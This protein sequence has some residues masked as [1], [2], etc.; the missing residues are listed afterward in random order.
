[1]T[2]KTLY[3]LPIASLIALWVILG[4]GCHKPDDNPAGDNL[5]ATTMEDLKIAEDFTWRTNRALLIDLSFTFSDGTPASFAPF[6]LFSGGKLILEATANQNGHFTLQH[7]VADIFNQVEVRSGNTPAI[8]LPLTPTEYHNLPAYQVVGDYTLNIAPV[9]KKGVLNQMHYPSR[10]TYGTIVFEDSWPYKADFDFNDMVIDFQ[11][12]AYLN[13]EAMVSDMLINLTLRAAGGSF[14][15]SFGLSF[16]N[17]WLDSPNNAPD[18]QTITVNDQPIQPR[19]TDYPSYIIFNNAHD[20][21][22][23]NTDPEKPYQEPETFRVAMHFAHPVSIES[24]QFPL[25]NPFLLVDGDPGREIHLPGELPTSLADPVFVRS[26]QDDSDP[27]A[28]RNGATGHHITYQ[29]QQRLPWAMLIYSQSFTYPA[30]RKSLLRGYNHF[31]GWTENL[32]PLNWYQD[33]PGYRN[34]TE[35]Y[36]AGAK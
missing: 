25:P 7:Q 28:W 2:N 27:L 8:T 32:T 24:L 35:L 5:P 9:S 11:T 17:N 26:G 16:R 23:G 29:T 19:N 34:N 4:S 33:A 13:D 18:I 30:E 1:M 36:T 6:S 3:N 14:K 20:F 22:A 15:N 12:T 21:I 10:D 31:Q